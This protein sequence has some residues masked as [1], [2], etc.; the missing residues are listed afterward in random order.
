MVF[1]VFEVSFSIANTPRH[2]FYFLFFLQNNQKIA[3]RMTRGER[4]FLTSVK[5]F[6]DAIRACYKFFLSRNWIQSKFFFRLWIENISCSNLW[7]FKSQLYWT[8]MAEW[9]SINFSFCQI[10]LMMERKRR[11]KLS[12]VYNL[13]KLS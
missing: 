8:T 7:C 6:D 4:K 11:W 13:K 3:F 12:R 9:K 1:W 10:D 5:K 2:H